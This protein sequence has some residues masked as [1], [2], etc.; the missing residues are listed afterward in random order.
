MGLQAALTVLLLVLAG[1]VVL[2]APSRP[3]DTALLLMGA[4][5]WLLV[6]A[7]GPSLSVYRPAGGLVC[8]VPILARLGPRPL[9]ALLLA[10]V[11][12]GYGI[13]TV[14]FQNVLV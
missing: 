9:A 13:S 3:I 5:L 6:H 10:L 4:T 7:A 14:F 8:L 2:R 12:L 1:V 11:A